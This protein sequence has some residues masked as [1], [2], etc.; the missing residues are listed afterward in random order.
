MHPALRLFSTSILIALGVGVAGVAHASKQA[1]NNQ[2]WG[3]LAHQ[4]GQLGL[5][6]VHSAASSP[7]NPTP[8]EPRLGVA[9]QGRTLGGDEFEPGNGGQGN[10]AIAVG[11]LASILKD[12]DGQALGV[13]LV[14]DGTPGNPGPVAV[15]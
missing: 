4:M 5:M 7:F 1:T 6:G 15:P 2:C 13:P 11:K 8:A 3:D 12:R 9:N 14:C 10:H